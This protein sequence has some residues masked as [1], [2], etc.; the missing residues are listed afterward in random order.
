[1]ENR[2]RKSRSAIEVVPISQNIVFALLFFWKKNVLRFYAK[3]EGRK[4]E[5]KTC[6]EI[7]CFLFSVSSGICFF[8]SSG[9]FD[10]ACFLSLSL[11]V[12]VSGFGRADRRFF[13][14]DLEISAFRFFFLLELFNRFPLFFSFSLRHC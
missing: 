8:F 12:F 1:M 11:V 7:W 10:M 13:F 3:L 5:K 4:E 14:L 9:G 2:R 6:I